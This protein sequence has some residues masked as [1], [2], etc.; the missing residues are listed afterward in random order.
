M[1]KILYVLRTMTNKD[2]AKSAQITREEKADREVGTETVT[3]TNVTNSS[4]RKGDRD[5]DFSRSR[6][7]RRAV[8]DTGQARIDNGHVNQSKFPL[9]TNGDQGEEALNGDTTSDSNHLALPAVIPKPPSPPK[10]TSEGPS[11]QVSESSNRPTA[12]GV[13]FPFKLGTHLAEPSWN[14]SVVTLQSQAGVVSPQ[15]EDNGKQL[16]ETQM[17]K[18]AEETQPREDKI[19]APVEEAETI[20]QEQWRQAPQEQK[21]RSIAGDNDDNEE[22]NQDQGRRRTM[23][24]S[25]GVLHYGLTRFAG[26]AS[27]GDDNRGATRPVIDRNDTA[28]LD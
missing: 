17:D 12:G 10:T 18:T 8:T 4:L 9:S 21:M 11:V 28:S 20:G 25:R 15:N 24:D 5:K 26:M 3:D 19:I 16:R 6:S 22:E 27:H 7:R 23:E 13:A 2:I 1:T 14:A